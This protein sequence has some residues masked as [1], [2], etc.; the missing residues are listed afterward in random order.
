MAADHELIIACL[1]ELGGIDLARVRGWTRLPG[2]ASGSSVYRLDLDHDEMLVLKVSPGP[3]S[4]GAWR[5]LRF[6]QEVAGH[7]PVRTPR[8]VAGR[9]TTGWTCLFLSVADPSPPA[10]EWTT[11]R[12]LEAARQLGLLHRPEVASRAGRH[13]WLRGGP[14]AAS[15]QVTSERDRARRIWG[16]LE[17]AQLAGPLLDVLDQLSAAVEAVPVCLVHGDCHAGNLLLDP[18]DGRLVWTDWQ[19]AGFGHGPEDLALLWQRGEFDGGRPPREEMLE[20]YARTRE[21]HDRPR[22]HRAAIGAEIRL[23]LLGWPSFLS[24]AP[25]SRREVIYRRLAALGRE[26]AAA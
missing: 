26:W 10:A 25:S 4:E 23:A 15:T 20:V 7:L 1:R 6:Y 9:T 17:Q 24:A 8:L 21:I 11:G 14:P 13:S 22:L 3:V 12:W 18:V 5:E 16:T 19:A 2:A